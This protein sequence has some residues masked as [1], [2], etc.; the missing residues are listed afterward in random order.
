MAFFPIA[1][2]AAHLT[3]SSRQRRHLPLVE[4]DKEQRRGATSYDGRAKPLRKKMGKVR[5]GNR[6]VCIDL[7]VRF[8]NSSHSRFYYRERVLLWCR[9]ELFTLL[10]LCF[11]ELFNP[12]RVKSGKIRILYWLVSLVTVES[13]RG[14]QTQKFELFSPVRSMS[15]LTSQQHG[16]Q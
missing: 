3:R 10:C 4:R 15:S 9:P 14:A 12:F 6:L 16:S 1:V 13:S 2:E 8:G 7:R 5:S 11:F